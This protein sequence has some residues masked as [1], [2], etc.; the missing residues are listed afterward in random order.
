MLQFGLSQI[1]NLVLKSSSGFDEMEM[2]TNAQMMKPQGG[3]PK[4]YK[5]LFKNEKESYDL[6][7][8]K[9]GLEDVEDALLYKFNKL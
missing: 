5:A 2:M 9:F 8:Y 3:Q 6:L 4:N 1:L 7:A